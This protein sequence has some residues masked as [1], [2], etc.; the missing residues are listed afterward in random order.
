MKKFMRQQRFLLLLLGWLIPFGLFAQEVTI[1]GKVT[2]ATDG[3]GLPGV[4][5]VVKGSTIGTITT[6][7]GTYS[8]KAKVGDVL[9]FSFIGFNAEERT[10]T[11]N[12]SVINLSMSSSVFGM[13]EV[14]VIGYGTV[15]K[16]DA[17]GAVNVIGSDKFNQGAITSAQSLITGKI[18][19]VI[20]RKSVV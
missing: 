19:G 6:P 18:P 7:M 11:S 15:K 8:I 1:T 3:S 17:T 20:D 9:V 4:S 5:I 2:D 16:S 14:V 12:L 10:V 13:D